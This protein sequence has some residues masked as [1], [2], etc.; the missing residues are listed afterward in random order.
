[1]NIS[2]INSATPSYTPA[3]STP[4]KQTAQDLKEPQTKA[5]SGAVKGHHHHHRH[6][7]SATTGTTQTA[8]STTSTSAVSSTSGT[9]L[10]VQA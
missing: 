4:S 3:A 6:A 7:S 10:N 9:L 1:M 8:A 2:N 5:S